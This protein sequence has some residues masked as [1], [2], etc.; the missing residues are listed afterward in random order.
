MS[1]ALPEFYEFGLAEKARE[2][3][4]THVLGANY[5]KTCMCVRGTAE[6][7]S[8]TELM[9]L[10]ATYNFNGLC[11]SNMTRDVLMALIG[12]QMLEQDARD[13]GLEALNMAH[14]HESRQ[15]QQIIDAQR[16][17]II[18]LRARIK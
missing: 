11:V 18:D 1:D 15:R 8:I 4:T 6:D 17:E 9:M 5:R 2:A 7:R 14:R 10:A 12:K 13:R 16:I 3:T